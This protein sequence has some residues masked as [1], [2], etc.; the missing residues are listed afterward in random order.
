MNRSVQTVTVDGE[1]RTVGR[2]DF[3]GGGME[4]AT[5]IARK[6]PKY[7]YATK[8]GLLMHEIAVMELRWWELGPGGHYWIRRKSPRVS[9]KTRCGMFFFGF[10]PEAE[11]PK[12]RPSKSTVCE[13]PRPDT[14]LCGRCQGNE[15]VFAKG[16][17]TKPGGPSRY[18]ARARLGCVVKPG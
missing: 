5:T 7:I 4:W 8:H 1:V 11:L 12:D 9:Y 10:D 13:L 2:P 3:H 17:Q 15:P 6:H 14:V 16:C 18:E